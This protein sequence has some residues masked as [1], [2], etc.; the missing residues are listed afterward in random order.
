VATELPYATDTL[1]RATPWLD[2]YADQWSTLREQTCRI[3]QGLEAGSAHPRTSQCLDERRI[4]LEG[5]LDAFGQATRRDVG[6]AITAAAGLPRLAQCTDEIWLAQQHSDLDSSPQAVRIRQQLT[7]IE[8]LVAAGRYDAAAPIMEAALQDALAHDHAPL[9]ARTHMLAGVV[10]QRRGDY[11]LAQRELEAAFSA[12]GLAGADLVALEA[13]EHLAYVVGD[14]KSKHEAGLAWGR[15]SAM[16]VD[17]LGVAEDPIAAS[18]NNT[19]GGVHHARGAF[20]EALAHY[21]RALAISEQE[22]GPDHPEVPKTLTNIATA[23]LDRADY[24]QALGYFERS[25]ALYEAV[26]GPDHPELVTTLNNLGNLQSHR[27]ELDKSLAAFDRARGLLGE[28]R[29]LLEASLSF[30]TGNAY[31]RA[32]R[33]RETLPYYEKA[34]EIWRKELGNEHPNVGLALVSMGISHVELGDIETAITYQ[35]RALAVLQ[36]AHEGDHP[37]VA[38]GLNNLASSYLT[39]GE[40]ARAEPML[41]QALEM[42]T[43]TRGS[44]H[45]DVAMVLV[46]LAQ[47]ARN[48]GEL[49]TALSLGQRALEIVT[50]G[51]ADTDASLALPLLSL[52][53]THF[54]R[55]EL[56]ESLANHERAL[57]I[58]EH[59]LGEDSRTTEARLGVAD[60]LLAQG[61]VDRAT[62]MLE[63]MRASI[64]DTPLAP[65]I[66][67]NIDFALARAR[68]AQGDRA[69]ALELARAARDA[70]EKAGKSSARDLAKVQAELARWQRGASRA[71]R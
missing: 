65:T 43:R 3:E 62:T 61:E 30:N 68:W 70:H 28:G 47:I 5:L 25:L 36:A 42:W 11:D 33:R 60:V 67:A 38:L 34:H 21:E 31:G 1:A 4:V 50:K 41:N 57:A 54:A 17:R 19:V 16:M 69:G 71:P 58:A 64:R 12:A 20:D 59:Q 46:N 9:V 8:S 10:A 35:Q 66:V 2:R 26:L 15:V 32:G 18:V 49:D 23:H 52:G 51:N 39:I 55:G 7:E 22:L 6:R 29:Q 37:D 40:D 56:A 24:E 13:A 27:G 44:G 45:P 48:R 14:I 63:G 53:L